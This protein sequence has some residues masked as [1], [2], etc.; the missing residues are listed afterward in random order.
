MCTVALVM[1]A[2]GLPGACSEGVAARNVAATM[3]M[4]AAL[5]SMTGMYVQHREGSGVT[6]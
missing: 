2:V 5:G 6:G 1:A 4:E 3:E